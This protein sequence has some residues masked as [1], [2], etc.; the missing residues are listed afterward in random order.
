MLQQSGRYL[1]GARLVTPVSRESKNFQDLNRVMERKVGRS[2][3]ILD[4]FLADLV[5]FLDEKLRVSKTHNIPLKTLLHQRV[6][7]PRFLPS[8]NFN[9]LNIL[10]D[11]ITL[12]VSQGEFIPLKDASQEEV[13]TEEEQKVNKD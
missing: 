4:A 10:R 3:E 12:E 13:A 6:G 11:L 1:E 5:Y 7:Q 8:L 2:A 9:H